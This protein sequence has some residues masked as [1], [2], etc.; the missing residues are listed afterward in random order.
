MSCTP[1]EV[2]STC[3]PSEYYDHPTRGGDGVRHHGAIF[4]LL[5]GS[6]RGYLWH[7]LLH[8][9]GVEP[10]AFQ[11]LLVG[12]F[13]KTTC[14]GWE[15]VE[16]VLNIFAFV[17]SG[18]SVRTVMRKRVA[19]GN[20]RLRSEQ[21]CSN[22]LRSVNQFLPKRPRGAYIVVLSS[23]TCKFG[24]KKSKPWFPSWLVPSQSE[25]HGSSQAPFRC[26]NGPRLRC[27]P[28]SILCHLFTL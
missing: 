5:L 10:P 14:A 3:S 28:L 21:Q 9:V 19:Q 25:A 20:F 2:P 1:S 4:R 11:Q 13:R 24:R 17:L 22:A 23:A 15:F 26:S 27:S 12:S 16:Y 6:A 18:V 8:P 7:S